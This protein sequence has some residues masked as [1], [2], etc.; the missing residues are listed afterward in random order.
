[1]TEVPICGHCGLPEKWHQPQDHAFDAVGGSLQR[2]DPR[3]TEVV[4]TGEKWSRPVRFAFIAS[5][6]CAIWG[7]LILFFIARRAFFHS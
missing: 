1:M 7:A 4:P 5:A 2:I 6:A 3:F